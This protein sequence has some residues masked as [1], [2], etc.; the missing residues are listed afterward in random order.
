MPQLKSRNWDWA[1]QAP[2]PLKNS[3]NEDL[4]STNQPETNMGVCHLHLPDS[5]RSNQEE[6]VCQQFE[7][8]LMAS[9]I[10]GNWDQSDAGNRTAVSVS[11][12][13][14]RILFPSKA[15]L[16]SFQKRS[17]QPAPSF[18]RFILP[19]KINKWHHAPK[20]QS[21]ENKN[22]FFSL[23]NWAWK[24]Q[25][26]G[27]RVSEYEQICHH[28]LAFKLKGATLRRQCLCSG[29]QLAAPIFLL[30][31]QLQSV[32]YRQPPSFLLISQP[33]PAS[34][35]QWGSK[36]QNSAEN[37]ESVIASQLDHYLLSTEQRWWRASIWGGI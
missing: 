27:L 31:P 1:R 36:R 29:S 7:G 10:V 14:G 13:P 19:Q 11:Y 23:D 22:H 16:V 17:F 35:R 21:Q 9:V 8:S 5:G 25:T 2:G 20:M 3:S 4:H 26:C 6:I 24:E 34:L 30:Y 18:V 33:T 15:S 28:H 37:W 12:R 32:S